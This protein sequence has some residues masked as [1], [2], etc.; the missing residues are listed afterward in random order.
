MSIGWSKLTF[1]PSDEAVA[2]L[3]SS[4]AWLI[5][6]PFTPLLFSVLG[7]MFFREESGKVVWLNTGTGELTPVA[8]SEI[9]FKGLL[10]TEAVEEWFLPALVEKLHAAGKVP[11]PG[12][13]YTYVTLP[14]FAEG[15]YEVENLNPVPAREHFSVTGQILKEIRSLPDGAKVKIS[16]ES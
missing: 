16:V 9:E 6:E 11:G 7:D 14:V 15:K 8:A 3:A 2:E 5:K 13:C 12:H 1:T 4:W 10:A